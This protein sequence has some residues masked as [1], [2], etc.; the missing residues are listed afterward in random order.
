MTLPNRRLSARPKWR[1]AAAA[2]ACLAPVLAGCSGAVAQVRLPPKA[3]AAP[4]APARAPAVTPS[5]QVAAALTGYTAALDQ[6]EESG[7]VTQARRLLGP[8]LLPSRINGVVAAAS[9]IWA[10]GDS[11]YGQH[12]L[13]ILSVRITG[14]HAFV[15]DCDDTSSMGLQVAATGQL[16]PGSAG[17]TDA[18]LVTRLDLVR[19]HWLVESQLPEDVPCAA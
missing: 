9:A 1:A 5:R 13:H 6:A 12:I 2:C 8:Y 14:R 4:A 19:G 16:V 15:H 10:S 18:N 3:A 7:N 17:V 11:F